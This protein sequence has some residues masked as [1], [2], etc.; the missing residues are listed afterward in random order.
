MRATKPD[1]DPVRPV[2]FATVRRCE[3]D[4]SVPRIA[5]PVP[6]KCTDLFNVSYEILLQTLER[7]FAHT[8]ETDGQLGTLADAT[9]ALML[10]ALKPLGSLITTLP[11]G[12]DHPSLNAGPSFE[13]FYEN[14]YLMPHREAAWAVLEERIREAARFCDL[15]RAT[16]ADEVARELAPV[17]DGSPES[18]T[19]WRPT[20]PTGARPAGSPPETMRRRH[21][22]RARQ[23]RCAGEHQNATA[24]AVALAPGARPHR[25]ATDTVGDHHDHLPPRIT[26]VSPGC[27]V[28]ADR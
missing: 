10:G 6:A 4:D 22:A 14:D 15:V 12:P 24:I 20:S 18:P 11:V 28:P 16:A 8:E 3:R 19:R 17:A 26:T 5:D 27:V 13:L 1:F 7:Y 9:V 23:T 2:I 21:R 25:R